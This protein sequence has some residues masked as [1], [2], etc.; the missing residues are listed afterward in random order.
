MIINKGAP[1]HSSNYYD[2]RNA[3]IQYI[4]IHYTA[5][6]GDTAKANCTY[7]SGANRSASAHYFVGDD[8]I[9]QSVPDQCAAW[10]VGG[11]SSYKHPHCRNMNSISI[12][13]CSRKDGNGKFYIKDNVVAQTIELTKY[14]MTKYSIDPDHVLRHYDVWNKQCPEPFVRNPELWTSFKSRLTEKA[15]NTRPTEEDI[16]MEELNALKGRV[17]KLEN[18]MIYNYLDDN[19]PSW[20]V[21]TIQKLVG[22]GILQGNEHGEL[23]LTD[24]LLRMLVINDRA[25]L[26]N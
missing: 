11:T 13:M 2:Y 10:A 17:D 12:E 15:V 23:G 22:K 16:D 7:F 9:Y 3:P 8:G 6:N 19:M 25:G 26:Y 14:L 20:A 21:P 1:C 5:N 24:E 4:V 18:K